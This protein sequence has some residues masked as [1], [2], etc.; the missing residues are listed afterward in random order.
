MPMP[1]VLEIRT[2]TRVRPVGLCIYCGSAE[3]LSDEHVVPFALGGNA[4]LPKAS[5]SR[6]S[7][8]TSEFERKVLRGF[9]LEARTAGGFPTRRPKERPSTFPLSVEHG[10]GL[11]PVALPS[12]ASPGF[13]H[14]PR[15]E[16]AGFL[17][18]RPH[19]N[20]INVCGI[21]TLV[22]GK[23]PDQVVSDLGTKTIQ[24]TVNIDVASFVRMISK[25]GYS[26]AVAAQGPFPLNEVPVLPLILGSALD[27]SAWVGSSEYNLNVEA[28]LPQYGLGLVSVK[29]TVDRNIEEI[30][31]ARV[32][33]FVNAGAT[34]YEVVVRRRR[35]F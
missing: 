4:I 10:E 14:L 8:I 30:L 24:T 5:C 20:G 21:E 2:S 9:I 19:V 13:L 29:A 22:F 15:L 1:E 33:L 27:G 16:A 25:I 12:V 11:K 23:A 3:N 7:A 31:I 17:T 35:M 32:K 18:G 26:F 6:C 28:R 34:G